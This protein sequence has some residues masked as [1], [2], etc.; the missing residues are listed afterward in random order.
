[1]ITIMFFNSFT[2][3]LTLVRKSDNDAIFRANA[4]D[5]GEVDIRKILWFLP[6]VIPSDMDK[7]SMYKTVESKAVVPIAYRARQCDT[8]TI[9]QSTTFD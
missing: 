2:Q 9:P 5:V 7:M 3:D 1:M 4:A 8:I 6:H